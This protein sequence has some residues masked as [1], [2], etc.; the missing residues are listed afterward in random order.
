LP[1]CSQP[2]LLSAA[3]LPDA[4]RTTRLPQHAN[5]SFTNKVGENQGERRHPPARR[6][7]SRRTHASLGR[8][9]V[10]PEYAR[11]HNRALV[12]QTLYEQQP[13]SRADLARETGLTR[14]SISDLVAGLLTDRL[15]VEIG[16][17]SESRPGKPA[18]LLEINRAAYQLAAI[19]LS[20]NDRLRGAL[21]DL[22]GTQLVEL[23]RPLDGSTGSAAMV[24]VADLLDELLA[25]AEAPILGVGIATPGVV[26]L[27][28]VVLSAPNLAWRDLALGRLLHERTG[29]A[30]HV[31][32]DANLAAMAEHAFGHAVDD[33]LLVKV[34]R[35]VGAG[36]LLD[37]QALLGSRFAAGEIGHVV[38]GTHGGAPCACGKSGCLETWLAV[39]RLRDALA[40]AD[41]CTSRDGGS[42]GTWPKR[43]AVLRDA[44]E[45]LGIAIA[46]VIAATNVSE[47]V[48]CGPRELLDGE[49]ADAVLE[50]VRE[51]T[52]P[53]LHGSLTVRVVDDP[54]GV[55][56]RGAAV[57]VLTEQ[58]GVS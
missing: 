34:G 16:Q 31:G 53:E 29:L 46:P 49:L 19:D 47:L 7:G 26:D 11:G 6:F 52:L 27:N 10:L 3:A 8:S 13:L 9:K 1:V 33:A 25:R 38:V 50:T 18:V 56:L 28:G 5:V 45:H 24:R 21:F 35:G 17:R 54:E 57:L 30:V 12:L 55:V 20:E 23:A 44:G 15:L 14:V 40:S 2:R 48:L 22:A 37:G 43:Q 39:P 51:R 32:N 4:R 36:L 42:A 58:L 41:R